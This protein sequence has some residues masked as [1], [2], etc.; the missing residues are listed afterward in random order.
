MCSKP[1]SEA[2]VSI[3]HRCLGL[4]Q[5]SPLCLQEMYKSKDQKCF[6]L[7]LV[8]NRVYSSLSGFAEFVISKVVCAV[9]ELQLWFDRYGFEAGLI[10]PSWYFGIQRNDR[11]AG[12]NLVLDDPCEDEAVSSSGDGWEMVA[13]QERHTCQTPA[14][15]RH[16]HKHQSKQ[17]RVW[18]WRRYANAG[19]HWSLHLFPP[20]ILWRFR[21]RLACGLWVAGCGSSGVCNTLILWFS[22]TWGIFCDIHAITVKKKEC[23]INVIVSL[24]SFHEASHRL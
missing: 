10:T 20:S 14:W 7:N 4:S 22:A 6:I 24:I 15:I 19:S 3:E 21:S 2:N 9:Q 8:R 23:H 12:S 18:P 13:K 17:W 11:M 1:C 16:D 5:E